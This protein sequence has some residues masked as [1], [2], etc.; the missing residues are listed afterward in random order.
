TTCLVS[1]LVNNMKGIIILKTNTFLLGHM[2]QWVLR[3][4][5]L[6]KI[7]IFKISNQP[8]FVGRQKRYSFPVRTNIG[9]SNGTFAVYLA[10]VKFS[11]SLCCM[12]PF[13]IWH[14]VHKEGTVK[15]CASVFGK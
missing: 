10:T 9:S 7:I 11:Y 6:F 12:L 13:F 4:V 15:F 2:S 5:F 8:Y 14:L 3:H 1:F